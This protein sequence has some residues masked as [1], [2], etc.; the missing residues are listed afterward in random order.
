MIDYKNPQGDISV[1]RWIMEDPTIISG[2][3][4]YTSSDPFNKIHWVSS[5]RRGELM[6]KN[7]DFTS[8]QR[9]MILLNIETAKPFWIKI[10]ENMIEKVI[11]IAAS[12][13]S[14]LL[15]AGMGVGLYTNAALSGYKYSEGNYIEP[16]CAP[17]QMTKILEVLARVSYNIHQDF[18]ELLTKAFNKAS[19]EYYSSECHYII[20][21]P[22]VTQE[23]VDIINTMLGKHCRISLVSIDMKNTDKI[24]GGARIFKAA[25]GEEKLE[26]V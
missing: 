8:N 20:V 18:E 3:R 22:I 25:G 26:A 17:G 21:T 7:F 11:D 6:V 16:G 24:R 12:V 19:Y 14:E 9:V 4:E 13:S 10:D 2:I 1:R 15:D 5:A 23:C